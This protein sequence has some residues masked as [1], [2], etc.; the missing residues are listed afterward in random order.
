MSQLAT[1]FLN[2]S[3]NMQYYRVGV[4]VGMI[5]LQGCIV[6]PLV[7]FT[8]SIAGTT[9]VQLPY[10]TFTTFLVLVLNLS[11]MPVKYTIPAFAATSTIAMGMVAYN[12]IF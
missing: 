11:D 7:L 9:A 10:I 12:L 6:A 5:M 2:W 1:N 8:M 3:D 4:I